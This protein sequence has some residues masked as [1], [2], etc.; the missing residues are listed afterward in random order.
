[1]DNHPFQICCIIYLTDVMQK[2]SGGFMAW[3]GSHRLM[4]HGFLGK[5]SCLMLPLKSKELAAEAGRTCGPV[6]FCGPRGTTIFWHHRM[7]H[8]PS[9]N[10]TQA[11]R[12]ALVADFLLND[13]EGKA[14]LPHEEDMWSDWAVGDDAETLAWRPTPEPRTIFVQPP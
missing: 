10:R 11:V 6:E 4:R 3:A 9:T 7:L 13:W 2:D 8:S 5:A 14:S 12:H 1:M